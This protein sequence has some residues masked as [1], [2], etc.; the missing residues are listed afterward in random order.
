MENKLDRTCVELVSILIEV[1]KGVMDENR[2]RGRPQNWL[3]LE[4][5]TV[6]SY[7]DRTRRGENQGKWMNEEQ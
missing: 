1:M 2:G 3:T 6:G 4:E 5:M 7:Q